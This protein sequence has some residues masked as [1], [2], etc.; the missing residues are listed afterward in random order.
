MDAA[1]AESYSHH[2]PHEGQERFQTFFSELRALRDLRGEKSVATL[3]T[4]S[5][6]I[7]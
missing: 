4:G 2:E 5:A 1:L 3:V 6:N 7:R